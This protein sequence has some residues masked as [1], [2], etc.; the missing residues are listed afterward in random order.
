MSVDGDCR[1]LDLLPDLDGG[2]DLLK[3]ASLRIIAARDRESTPQ[4]ILIAK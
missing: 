2:R 1:G 3:L 4:S